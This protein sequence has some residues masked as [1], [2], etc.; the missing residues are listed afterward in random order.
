MLLESFCCFEVQKAL[1][2]QLCHLGGSGLA[3]HSEFYFLKSLT[4]KL[5][6]LYQNMIPPEMWSTF[7]LI[8]HL[9]NKT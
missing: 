2:V 9:Q 4:G 3:G 1:A 5:L 7:S 6:K 8:H